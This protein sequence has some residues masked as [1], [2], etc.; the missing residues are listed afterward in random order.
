MQTSTCQASHRHLPSL[1]CA[2][3]SQRRHR[4][5]FPASLSLAP[6]SSTAAFSRH[7]PHVCPPI[8]LVR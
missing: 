5:E 7:W 1:S 6:R 2:L 3:T 8:L 4:H